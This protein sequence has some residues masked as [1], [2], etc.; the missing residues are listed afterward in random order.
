[1]YHHNTN[2][3]AFD[4]NGALK[5][6]R[7]WRIPLTVMDALQRDV[8]LNTQITDHTRIHL[9]DGRGGAVGQRPGFL[10]ADNVDRSSVTQAYDTYERE[11]TS[12]W[13][14]ARHINPE[15]GMI[16][17]SEEDEE[18]HQRKKRE[19]KRAARPG[20][21]DTLDAVGAAYRD[22]ERETCDAWRRP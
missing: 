17:L 13:R 10:F 14:D 7:T 2:D 3:D 21:E 19:A 1:M 18:E 9:H 12:A 11:A 22:Y 15:G 16:E 20:A 5:D 4:E 8:M 6:G